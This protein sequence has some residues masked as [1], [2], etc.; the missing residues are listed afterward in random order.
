MTG[1]GFWS[2]EIV[3]AMQITDGLRKP[4]YV[5]V[6]LVLLGTGVV[7]SLGSPNWFVQWFKLRPMYGVVGIQ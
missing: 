6:I 4:T 5:A 3:L 7:C 1:I 2:S